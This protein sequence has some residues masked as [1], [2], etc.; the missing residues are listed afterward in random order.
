MNKLKMF[1]TM[2][3]EATI[4]IVVVNTNG[5]I[6]Q[7]NSYSE[8]LFRY[9]KGELISQKI[10]ILLPDSSRAQHVK[11]RHEYQENPVPR[12][13]GENLELHGLRKDGSQFPIEI[14]LSN[15]KF[16][17]ETYNIAYI[18]DDSVQ[19]GMLKEIKEGKEILEEAQKLAHVGSFE[20]DLKTEE[21]KMSDEMLRIFGLERP[22]KVYYFKDGIE[23]IHPDDKQTVLDYHQKMLVEKKGYNF[24]YRIISK[25]DGLKYLEVKRDLKFD[26]QGN[27]YKIIGVVQD[28]TDLKKAQ[29]IFEDISKIVDESLNEIF[30]FDAE[31]LK[32]IQ[33]NKGA[34]KNLGYTLE[35]MQSMTPVEI[36]PEFDEI[37]FSELILPL[38]NKKVDKLLFE[39]IHERKDKTSYPVEVHLQYSRL[40]T[41]PVFVA[42]VL[43]ISER[44][45]YELRMMMQTNEME[46]R[47][48]ERTRELRASESKLKSA[49]EKER[50]LGEL[51]SRF[52]SMASHEFR[53]PLS[54]IL[55]SANLIGRYE[56]SE[57]QEKRMRHIKRIE[58]SVRNLT[59]I[60]NDFLSLEK[61][62]SGKIGFNPAEF[63][64]EEYIN[65]IIE[66][67]NLTA[68]KG[69]KIIHHHKGPNS[70]I[71]DEH[72]LKNILINLLSNAI[73]YSPEEKNVEIKTQNE[74][75]IIKIQVKDYGIGIPESEQKNMFTRFFRANNVTNIQGT[76]L[77]LTIV[78]RYL[79][80]MN[81]KIW[82]ESNEGE[83]TTFFVE[84]TNGKN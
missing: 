50:E 80:L 58:S 28:V 52:V 3:E 23:L 61:L 83:G 33:V 13:M 22:K 81:G 2:F 1:E 18:S 42:I 7:A 41:Q 77:G 10:E 70:I 56:Q 53:T 38:K 37:Q 5:E 63:K 71:T 67:V 14:N 54:S 27:V 74:H 43:D 79:K 8:N 46:E 66:E 4:G 16:H 62:E 21:L 9:K 78:T 75:E 29:N 51:K 25:T 15:I 65:Q 20:I 84:I 82:F 73:K 49:L 12:C 40:G 17:G 68:K 57:Q 59:M 26:K 76:G 47:I 45:R 6:M 39:T 24:G 72:L 48:I 35:E 64:I 60:L 34:R 11:N 69:Q 55:S 31:T 19:Q 36:K 32:F 30:I 44:K